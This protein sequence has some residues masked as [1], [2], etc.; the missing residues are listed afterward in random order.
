MPDKQDSKNK[1]EITEPPALEWLAAAIGLILVVGAVG[2]MIYQAV[3]QEKTPPNINI[4]VDSIVP[5]EGGF[6]VG[7]RVNNRG[8]QT[9][10][11]LNIEG[12]LKKGEESIE[13]SGV[14]LDYAPSNSERKGGLFFT[15]NPKDFDLQI[16]ATGYEE[17]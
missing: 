15:K 10:S 17:P 2:F 14:T 3:A 11:A 13:T 5:T 4:S 8:T 9:A 6:R 12:E 7:F 1:T 16:R